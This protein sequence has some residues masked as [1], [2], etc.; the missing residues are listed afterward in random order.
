MSSTR[1]LV[2][3]SFLTVVLAGAAHAQFGAASGVASRFLTF[4]VGGGVSV[5]VTDAAD[6][7]KNGFNG[8]AFV[9]LNLAALPI[10]PRFDI[11]F[12]RFDAKEATLSSGVT[13]ASSQLLS[14]LANVTFPLMHGPIQP[15][16]LAGL[17][18]ANV[19]GTS[20]TVTGSSSTTSTD[21]TIDGGAG[22]LLRLGSLSAYVEGRLDNVYTSSDV[23][24]ADQIKVVPVTVGLTF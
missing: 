12:Q 4:G 14:G 8:H 9:R 7:L 18:I 22:V 17:G 21:F 10:A 13:S 2:L 1:I 6:A 19:K 23:I 11:S 5:P 3:T 15:Y 20:E 16:V 24:D